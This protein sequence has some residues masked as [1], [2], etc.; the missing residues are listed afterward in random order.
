MYI[1]SLNLE[2][3]LN[4]LDEE[5]KGLITVAQLDQVLQQADQFNFPPKALDTVFREM[6]G[7]EIGEVDRNCVI[8]IDAFMESIRN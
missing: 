8:K 1:S 6:L 7:G 5:K 4:Q 3:L 2:N